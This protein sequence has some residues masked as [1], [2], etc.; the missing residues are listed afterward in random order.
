MNCNIVKD[1][2]PLYIDEC[3]SAESRAEVEKHIETCAECRKVFEGMTATVTEEEMNFE[4]KK[5]SRINDWKASA[6]QSVLFLLSF[7][8]IIAGVYFEAGTNYIDW[9]N[10]LA[11]FNVVLPA[12]GFMLSLTNWYFIRLYKSK[13]AFSRCS[14]ALTV[15]I[16]VCA[17]VWC[18][19]HYELNPLDFFGGTVADFFEGVLFIFGIGIFL[20]VLFAVLS[21]ILSSFYAKM[22][23]K[24]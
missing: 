19:F 13:K 4:I 5:C 15:L 2:L 18:S 8:L 7:L 3:C 10:G 14:C 9:G 21:K 11:A 17:F 12:T 24:E 6:L 20:T 23:G 1:L 16:T 22:L